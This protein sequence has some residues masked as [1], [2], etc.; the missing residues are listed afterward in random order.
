MDRENWQVGP[1]Y[2]YPHGVRW[3]EAYWVDGHPFLTATRSWTLMAL[4]IFEGIAHLN[5]VVMPEVMTTVLLKP[6]EICPQAMV[7]LFLRSHKFFY[8]LQSSMNRCK[9]PPSCL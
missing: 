4:G 2:D 8:S 1:I 5:R 3:L 7:R 6:V 9:A